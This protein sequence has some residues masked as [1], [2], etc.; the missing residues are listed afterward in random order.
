MGDWNGTVRNFTSNWRELR[1]VVET[2]KREE[3]VFNKLRGRM[4][5]YFT[6]NEV[7]YNICKKG[8]SKT[9][10]LHILVQQLKA[11]ELAL[12][13]RLEVI[14]VPGT[15]MI[16]QETDGLSRGIWENSF[17]TYFKSFA[18]EVFLPDLPSLSLTKWALS[19]IEI[20]EEYAP[21]WNVET[22]TSLWQPKKMMHTNTFWALSPG[23]SRQGFTAAIMAWV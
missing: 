20:H 2:P 16:T 5:F 15:T 14:H 10:S 11:L 12:G 8:S 6:D 21:W 23:I 18:V 13:C 7:T 1:T 4:V 19:H 17:N 3:V 9:L 22:D